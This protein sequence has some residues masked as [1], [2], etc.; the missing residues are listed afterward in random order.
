MQIVLPRE[1]AGEDILYMLKKA[2]EEQTTRTVIW[3]ADRFPAGI[4]YRYNTQ[5]IVERR[6]L[7]ALRVFPLFP[8]LPLKRR[9]WQGPRNAFDDV[10]LWLSPLDMNEPYGEVHLEFPDVPAVCEHIHADNEVGRFID[11]VMDSFYKNLVK[12]ASPLAV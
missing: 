3:C 12:Q 4:T 5:G 10:E 11:K 1:Y 2:V 6:V 8:D 7:Q 9:W